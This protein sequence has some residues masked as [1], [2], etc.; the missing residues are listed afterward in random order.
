MDPTGLAV[1]IAGLFTS[2]LEVVNKVQSYQTFG[3]DSHVL[4]TRFKVARARFERWG[5]GVGIEQGKLLPDHHSALDDK[6]TS[7]VVTDVLHIIIKTICDA[8]NAPPR[9]TRAAGPGDDDFP[10]LR[11]PYV[12]TSESRIRK[13]TWALWGK[14]GRTEQVELFE[15]LVQELHNLL[16][17]AIPGCTFVVDGLD[18]CACLDN[19]STSVAK[20]LH[21]ITDAVAGTDTRVLLVSRD[22][23]EIR[24][25]L[26]DDARESFAEY[27]IRPEDVRSDTAAYSRS[28]VSRTLPNKSDDVRSTL[29]VAMTNRC[30]GQFLW[31]KMQEKSLGGWMNKKQ[32]QRAIANTPTGLDNLYDDNWTRIAQLGEWQRHRAV[33]LLRWTA[34]A[35]RPLTIYEITEAALI[36]ESED[37]PLEDLPDDVDDEYVNSGIVGLCGPLLEVRN[38]PADPSPGRRTVHLPHFSV[39]QYLLRQLPLPDWIRQNSRLQISHEKLQNT[40]LAKA[41]L[42]YVG[43]RQVWDGVGHDSP[44]GQSFRRYA[45]TAWHQHVH[46]GVGNEAEIRRLCIKFLD[47]DNPT[48]DAWRSLIDSE[49]AGQR[50]KEAE[51]IPPGPLYYAIGLSLTDVATSLISKQNAKERSSLGRSALGIACVNGHAEVVKLLLGKGA[52][53]SVAD[54]NGMTPLTAASTFGHTEVVKEILKDVADISVASNDGSTPLNAASN[55]GHIEVVK[56]LLKQRADV[57]LANNYGWIPLYAAS[58]SGH[59]EVVRL[60]LKEGAN[61]SVANN[62][63]WTPLYAASNGGHSEVVRL[64]LEK[65]ANISVANNDGWMPLLVASYSGYTE[66]VKVFLEGQADVSIANKDGLTPLI[67]ASVNGHVEVVKLLLEK[68]ASISIANNDGWTPLNAASS[69]GHIEVVKELLKEGANISVAN[70]DGWTPLYAASNGG[71]AEVV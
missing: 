55:H 4:D 69:L 3:T 18:E 33:T 58:N 39:R 64:L 50:D 34:F 6:D 68:R 40:V 44:L 22:E 12:V 43:L 2:C 32:L 13:M 35:L 10:G 56:E 42:Q 26:I 24:H 37:L 15:K 67:A 27:K 23:P 65:G 16:L 46:S 11:R 5:P 8:S 60:L 7:T 54:N 62:N 30:Q 49:D 41:C 71:H 9:R 1:G 36:L 14:G 28:I 48:W 38:D 20:F 70:N 63:G 61:I 59:S 29:S 17:H 31:L 52:D 21:D 19:S 51:A 47:R 66:V 25:A 53:I 57:S 45:A